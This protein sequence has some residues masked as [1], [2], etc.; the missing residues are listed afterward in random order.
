[1]AVMINGGTRGGDR[2]SVIQKVIMNGVWETMIS[3]GYLR[4]KEEDGRRQKMMTRGAVA[5][6]D[7]AI[8]LIARTQLV[9]TTNSHEKQPELEQK[10]NWIIHTQRSLSF[11][12]S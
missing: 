8:Q 1:M 11:A 5:G 10:Q 4:L 2:I 3:G 9:T 7:S 12:G 6:G